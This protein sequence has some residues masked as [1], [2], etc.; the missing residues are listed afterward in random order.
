MVYLLTRF[1]HHGDFIAKEGRKVLEYAHDLNDYYHH[2][3]ARYSLSKDC[4][5]RGHIAEAQKWA[6]ES[7]DFGR[8]TGFGPAVSL[9]LMFVALCHALREEFELAHE[10]SEEAIGRSVSEIEHMQCSAV[11]GAVL[12]LQGQFDDARDLMARVRKVAHQDSFQVLLTHVEIPYGVALVGSGDVKE[13]LSA[14]E[15]AI[16]M[17]SEWRNARMVAWAHLVLGEIHLRMATSGEDPAE[18]A[19]RE[20]DRYL[21]N[22]VRVGRSAG[23]DGHVAEAM[24]NLGLLAKATKQFK[25]SKAHLDEA[26]R[27]AEPLGW[28]ELVSKIETARAKL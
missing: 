12:T 6:Q 1:I 24:L 17:F 20:A 10:L 22:A 23:T 25:D 21:W 18:E 5:E 16:E 2:A 19:L 14:L 26:R 4:L 27:V 15:N 7:L 3:C 9:G 28:P 13:G 11:K 8:Q